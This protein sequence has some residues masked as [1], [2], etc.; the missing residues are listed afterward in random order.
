MDQEKKKQLIIKICCIIAAI[1][2]RVYVSNVENPIITYNIKRVPVEILNEDKL[3][4]SGLILVDENGYTVD[5]TIKGPT[6][7]VKKLT[8][9]DFKVMVDLD[10]L[11]LKKG[12]NKILVTVEDYPNG[13][14]VIQ[15]QQ[16]LIPI[17]LDAYIEKEFKVSVSLKGNPKQGY[18]A[19]KT[20]KSPDSIVVSGAEK[21]ISLIK[22]IVAEVQLEGA[23]KDVNTEATVKAVDSTGAEIKKVGLYPDKIKVN[24]PV[25]KTKLVPIKVNT[26]GELEKNLHLKSIS[27][28]IQEIKISGNEKELELI[29]FIETEKIDLQ[30]IKDN[31]NISLKIVV[32]EG[33]TVIDGTEYVEI[34]IEIEK[35][36][37]KDIT[38]LITIS[39]LDDQFNTQIQYR[40]I[41]LKIRGI[42]SV[43]KE[44]DY[45][46]IKCIVDLEGLKEGIHIVPIYIEK[47]ENI[48]IVQSDIESVKIE[49][50]KKEELNDAANEND[51]ESNN[52]ENE[53]DTINTENNSSD[54][55]FGETTD[56][57]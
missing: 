25:D 24:I 43:I 18:Y 13:V 44:L 16:M 17:H 52:E 57:E 27:S 4:Y 11:A 2:L 19:H 39:N 50:E 40:T 38:R 29:E 56:N 54:E 3:K 33:I 1:V 48:E 32:P 20:N 8:K 45:D 28:N 10:S 6:S 9:D 49:L 46:K 55:D 21:E 15:N 5:L 14:N 30:S 34:K 26:F 12:E 22:M 37:D 23:D 42:E 47:P 31:E 7:Q 51:A 53:V 36:V 35:I 41:N